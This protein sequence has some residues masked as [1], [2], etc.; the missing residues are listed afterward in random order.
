MFMIL[1]AIATAAPAA[2]TAAPA[3]AHSSS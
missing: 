3:T 1:A 2:V